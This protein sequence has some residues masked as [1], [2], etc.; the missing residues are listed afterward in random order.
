M[1]HDTDPAD[2]LTSLEAS[3]GAADALRD[4]E[5]ANAA[6]VQRHQAIEAKVARTPDQALRDELKR[7]ARP[8]PSSCPNVRPDPKVLVQCGL[9]RIV[10]SPSASTMPSATPIVRRRVCT[11]LVK[12]T[13]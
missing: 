13:L 7:W 6:A 5:R 10:I 8:M 4:V 2:G 12:S 9:R 3:G 11:A 1:T